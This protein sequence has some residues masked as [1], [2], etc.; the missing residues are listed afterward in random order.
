MTGYTPGETRTA[1]QQRWS[2][3]YL[4]RDIEQAGPALHLLGSPGRVV[5]EG[6]GYYTD[7][8]EVDAVLPVGQWQEEEYHAPD[9]RSKRDQRANRTRYGRAKAYYGKTYI[10]PRS[11]LIMAGLVGF[12]AAL[13]TGASTALAILHSFN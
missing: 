6:R 8:T 9:P 7:S 4:M 13:L 5:P 1:E 10:I 12:G 3:Y 2:N 11:E